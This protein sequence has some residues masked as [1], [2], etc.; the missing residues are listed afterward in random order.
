MKVEELLALAEGKPLR[1]VTKAT[2]IALATA[3]L[4]VVEACDHDARATLLEDIRASGGANGDSF[5]LGSITRARSVRAWI[6]QVTL[7]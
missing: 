1:P 3:L 6:D 5:V 4:G 7:P 2:V